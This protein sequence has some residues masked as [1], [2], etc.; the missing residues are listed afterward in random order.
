MKRLVYDG[1]IYTISSAVMTPEEAIDTLTLTTEGY[2][3][4]PEDLCD[5]D[6]EFLAENFADFE[7]MSVYDEDVRINHLAEEWGLTPAE[8]DYLR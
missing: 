5:T 2:C 6:P 4:G 3:L 8:I 1:D 7:E